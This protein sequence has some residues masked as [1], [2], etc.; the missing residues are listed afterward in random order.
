MSISQ[1]ERFGDAGSA[2]EDFYEVHPASNA[3]E[4]WARLE[5][6]RARLEEEEE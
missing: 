1:E 6:E 3:D 2:A 4:I 5:A